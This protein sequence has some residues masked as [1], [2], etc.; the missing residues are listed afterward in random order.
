[1]TVNEPDADGREL[2][3]TFARTMA[4]VGPD[5]GT[6]VAAST[7]QGRSIRRRRRL[8]VAAAVTAVAALAVG[9]TVALR[10]GGGPRDGGTVA[11][12]ATATASTAPTPGRRYPQPVEHTDD[13]PEQPQRGTGP[14]TGK[15]AM[16]G[17]T[18][19]AALTKALPTA[20][21][22]SDYSG[23][24]QVSRTRTTDPEHVTTVADLLYD[25]GSGP[26][27]VRLWFEGGFGDHRAPDSHPSLDELFSCARVNADGRLRYCSDSVLPDGTRVLRT[28]RATGDALQREVD[29]L[30][31]DRARVTLDATNKAEVAGQAKVQTVRDGL[32]LSLDQLQAAATGADLR[33]WT[34]PEEA[35]R[36]EQTIRP[37][38]D[39]SP[40]LNQPTGTPATPK[41][42]STG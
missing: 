11:A 28:E 19:L 30:R 15:V 32:P 40:E 9:G 34:T 23:Y 33:E 38:H 21:R 22:T 35:Q 6:L 7:R 1:M 27:N 12:A 8:T 42:D 13:S 36:A 16:T 37:F 5:L 17:R 18:A 31:P 24:S 41:P 20:E 39:G 29:V 3:A 10:T 14:N 4:G 26:A 25:D 2:S